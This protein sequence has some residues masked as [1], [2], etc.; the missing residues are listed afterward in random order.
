VSSAVTRH[1]GGFAPGAL[2]EIVKPGASLFWWELLAGGAQGG[3]E[4]RLLVGDRVRYVGL[5]Y[6]GGSDGVTVDLFEAATGER[7]QFRPSFY[8]LARCE[9]LK[10]SE[11]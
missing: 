11:G 4:H 7:G 5:T 3:R 8:G 9:F 6:S 2:Y 10:Q 1:A